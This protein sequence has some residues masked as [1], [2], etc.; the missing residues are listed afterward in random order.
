MEASSTVKEPQKEPPTIQVMDVSLE[1]VNDT[2]LEEDAVEVSIVEDGKER[3]STMN[4]VSSRNAT[5]PV[6]YACSCTEGRPPVA[7]APPAAT[8]YC[9]AVDSVGGKQVGCCLVAQRKR[10]YRP[11]RRIAFMILCDSHR[12]RIRK[13]FCC[14]GCGLFCTQ[15]IFLNN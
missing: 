9:Q 10:F 7:I 11:S 6:S 12:D 14:P 8:L 3:K 1:K 13:H 2:S 4:E 5:V 15:V